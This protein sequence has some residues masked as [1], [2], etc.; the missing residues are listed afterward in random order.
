MHLWSV[1]VCMN[2]RL[3]VYLYSMLGSVAPEDLQ[4]GLSR[5]MGSLGVSM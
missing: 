5:R 3:R 4:E 2:D 1:S